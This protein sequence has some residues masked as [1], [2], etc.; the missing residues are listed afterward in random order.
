MLRTSQFNR[1]FTEGNN[2]VVKIE[3]SDQAQCE[4]NLQGTNSYTQKAWE[5]LKQTVIDS[6]E[7]MLS[8]TCMQLMSL[9]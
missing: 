8:M 7:S 5:L 4:L 9:V 1:D 2:L 6:K 3:C